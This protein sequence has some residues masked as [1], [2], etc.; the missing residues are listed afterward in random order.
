MTTGRRTGH[1]SRVDYPELAARTRRFSFGAPRAVSVSAD[2]DRV[3]FLR[4][5]GPEDP[6]DRLWVY[7]VGSGTER[8]VGDPEALL[9]A[10]SVELPTEERALR[11][12]QRLSAAGIGDPD[13]DHR[14]GRR[15]AP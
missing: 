5:A 3:I 13:T 6:V 9:A 1:H 11:E 15:P 14:A 12:R 4:S 7:D 8:L 10:E 2:G